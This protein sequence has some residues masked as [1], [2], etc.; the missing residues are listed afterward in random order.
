MNGLV[1]AVLHG[2]TSEPKDW[3]NK[4]LRRIYVCTWPFSFLLRMFAVTSIGMVCLAML[5][6]D[7]LYQ[8]AITTWTG[9]TPAER[10]VYR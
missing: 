8:G 1:W 4:W 10:G 9:K 2:L 5:S 7:V 3:S 6:G